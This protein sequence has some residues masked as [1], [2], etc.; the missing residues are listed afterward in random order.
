MFASGAAIGGTFAWTC[1]DR[2]GQ[3]R[4]R[5][6]TPNGPTLEGLN[7]FLN[8]N[9]RAQPQT[10]WYFGLIDQSGYTGL[11][12]ADTHVSHPGWAEWASYSGSR[13]AWSPQPAA[14]GVMGT[15]T[16]SAWV[17]TANGQLRGGFLASRAA[18]GT[19]VGAVIYCT[20]VRTTPRTVSIGDTITATYA[21]T[22]RE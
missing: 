21:V 17:M 5:D 16:G 9:F 20:A 10:A 15:L 11:S 1:R 4:W 12:P 2:R 18:T 22:F 6:A 7:E 8:R 19:G 3:V 14:G 13:P